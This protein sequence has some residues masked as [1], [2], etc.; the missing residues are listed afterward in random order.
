[1]IEIGGRFGL[2]MESL[3]ILLAGQVPGQDHLERDDAVQ[4]QL[5][6]LIDHAHSSAVDFFQQLVI[7]EMSRAVGGRS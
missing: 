7:A 5:P 4:A 6:S 1:M 2:A 3:D